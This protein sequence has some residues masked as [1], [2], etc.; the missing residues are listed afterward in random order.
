[1]V[2]EFGMFHFKKTLTIDKMTS[3]RCLEFNDM[4]YLVKNTSKYVMERLSNGM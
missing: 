3:T 4:E 1:M 2:E